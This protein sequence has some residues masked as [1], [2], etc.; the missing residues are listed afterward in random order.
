MWGIKKLFIWTNERAR[1]AWR[2]GPLSARGL[3]QLPWIGG[4]R[5]GM[6][7]VGGGGADRLEVHGNRV[8]RGWGREGGWVWWEGS[9]GLLGVGGVLL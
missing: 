3:C 4:N 2:S 7:M 6:L 9:G 5:A 1:F 8:P